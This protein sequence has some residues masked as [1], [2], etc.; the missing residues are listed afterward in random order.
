ML[1][2]LKGTWALLEAFSGIQRA[3]E[4]IADAA[5]RLSPP[6]SPEGQDDSAVFYTDWEAAVALEERQ[7]KFFQETGVRLPPGVEP[8]TP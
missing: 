3:L 4:R 2:A 8:P 5:E 7:E 6:P 1:E